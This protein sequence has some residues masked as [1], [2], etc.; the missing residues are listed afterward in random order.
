LTLPQ[1]CE[2]ASKGIEAG[3]VFRVTFPFCRVEV[4]VP[5]PDPEGAGFAT[6]KSWKPGVEFVAA[7]YYGDDTDTICHGEGAMVLTVEAVFKPGRFPAR[8]F[9]TRQWVD[10][11]GK[12]FGK[13]NLHIMTAQAFRRRASGY[14]HEYRVES[15]ADSSSASGLDRTKGAM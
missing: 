4:D 8:V 5:D 2:A 9:F 1:Q 14:V 3:Q 13:G 12:T 7:G 15:P 6:I 10:P 11:D